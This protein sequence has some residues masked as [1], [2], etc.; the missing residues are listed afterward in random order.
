M[1]FRFKQ[2]AVSHAN[3]SMKVG[4]DAVIIGSWVDIKNSQTI[5]DIG[6][7][8]GIIALM[9]AQKNEGAKIKAIDIDEDSIH[10]AS[11]NF[12]QSPWSER[13]EAECIALQNYG[14]SHK[15]Q[16]DHIIS[17]PPFFSKSTPAPE[18][19]RHNARHTDTLSAD[20]FFNYSKLLLTETGKI[21]LIIPFYSSNDW[22]KTAENYNLFPS[23]ITNVIS[24]PDKPIERIL[25]EFSNEKSS[26]EAKEFYIRK[27]KG[28][29]YS[30][31]YAELTNDFY[32]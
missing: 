20:D 1:I 16:F 13:L 24:Y 10:E 29:G 18:K 4:T 26:F 12:K 25:I 11:Q 8:S 15:N 5:L 32:L 2:F 21:S 31:D 9:M 6:T 14:L 22:I 30:D 17:N 23:R 7:G 19:A 27:G 3:S 28:L